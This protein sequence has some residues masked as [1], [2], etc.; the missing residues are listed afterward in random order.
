MKKVAA[1]LALFVTL[2]IWFYLVHWLLK[3]NGA[4]EL[5]MFLFWAY[6]P[7]TILAQVLAQLATDE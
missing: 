4:G 5:Q 7:A 3:A 6:V 2:P 1:I